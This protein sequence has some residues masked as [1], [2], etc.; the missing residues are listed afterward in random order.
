MGS[1]RHALAWL[2]LAG[3]FVGL[4]FNAK[5]LAAYLVVPAMGVAI[6]IASGTWRAPGPRA[7]WCSGPTAIVTSLPWILIVDAVPARR[8]R[9]SA[10]ARTTPCST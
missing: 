1:P 6:L 3:T 10:A 4:A 2:V 5:M 8:A 7:A 9:G